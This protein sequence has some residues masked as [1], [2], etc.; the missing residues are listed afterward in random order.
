MDGI[1]GSQRAGI[2]AARTDRSRLAQ[3]LRDY[4]TLTK[5]HII[6]LLLVTTVAPMIAAL[7]GW[8]GW[9]LVLWT[10]AGGYLM[11]GGANAVNM[12]IDRDI[13]AVMGR[14]SLRPIP[15]GRMHPLHVLAYGLL[16]ALLAFGIFA[17]H[18]N[19]LSA[20]LALAG[21]LYYVLIYTRWLK[22]RS[23]QNIVIGGGAGAFPPLVGWAAATGELTWTAAGLFLIVVLWTPPHF[24]ALALVKKNDYARAG[25]PMAPNVW[26]D[27]AT[28]RQM[29]AYCLLLVAASVLLVV[30][31]R[32][33]IVYA[34]LATL[35][36]LWF[37]R[38]VLDLLRAGSLTQPAWIVYRRSLLYLALLFASLALDGLVSSSSG[39][40]RWNPVEAVAIPAAEAAVL[41]GHSPEGGT[42]DP[43]FGRPAAVR[44]E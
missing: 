30:E 13:D 24:W 33:G 23:P 26:G 29:L 37:L 16:L 15:S 44:R 19:P 21:F 32:L 14:T 11:A 2:A 6:V 38:S 5:P 31:G 3:Q 9:S 35:L 18:V 17:I 40:S 7:G 28:M 4:V 42:G 43:P 36:G 12:Y 34:V 39:A 1:T 10:V 8:P 22:R 41:Q 27:R 25:I 20:F